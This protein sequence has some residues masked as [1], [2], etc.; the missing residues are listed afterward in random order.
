MTKYLDT[1]Q[2]SE[3]PPQPDVATQV[4]TNPRARSIFW[5]LVTGVAGV[6]V[7]GLIFY[8]S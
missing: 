3:P 2:D 5:W 4:R 6:A 7:V 1:R 8:V